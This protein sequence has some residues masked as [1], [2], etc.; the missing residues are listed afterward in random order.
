MGFP[1]ADIFDAGPAVVAF[2]PHPSRGRAI[3]RPV[4]KD[5]ESQEAEFDSG[6]LSADAAVAQAIQ[7]EGEK[8]IVI[9]DVQDN[10]GAGATS[11]TTGLLRALVEGKAQNAILAL[12]ND[13]KTAATAH[14][15]GVGAQFNASLAACRGCPT[16][17]LIRRR[18][19]CSH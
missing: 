6:L 9:A 3:S 2:A 17:S 1:P 10:P 18:A 4:I 8:P 15:L 7:H 16:W 12:L 11:D 13:P 14:A 5:F 19:E